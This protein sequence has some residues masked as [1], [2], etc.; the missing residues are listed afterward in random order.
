MLFRSAASG[1][2]KT[3]KSGA[4]STNEAELIKLRHLHPIIADVLRYRELYKLK[5]TYVDAL[6]VLVGKDQRI[7][8]TWNQMGTATGRISSASPNLQNIPIRSSFGKDIRKAFTAGKGNLLVAFDY[9]Q[10]ELRIAADMAGDEKMTDAF[11]RG[12]DIHRLTAAEVNNVPLEK[13]TP[14]LRQKAKTLNFGVLYGMGTRAFAESA[15]VTRDEARHFIEEYFRD[16]AGIA[17]FIDRTKAEAHEVG[18]TKTAFGRKRFFP[19]LAMTNFRL[20]RDAERMAVNHPIQGTGA[21]IMKKAMIGV[22]AFIQQAGLSSDVWMLLQ[23]HDELMFE[24]KK[25]RIEQVVPEIRR[26]LE[27]IWT[28]KVPMKVEVK[29]GTNWGTLK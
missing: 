27:S 9:S 21:D 1:I 8:T 13:V 28:G 4:L 19:D 12:L 20:Q 24:I 5:S 25:E 18:F 11:R 26:I 22:A 10:L 17:R 16:F 15:G 2:K 29:K 23:I 3:E 7:H 6:P 14:E